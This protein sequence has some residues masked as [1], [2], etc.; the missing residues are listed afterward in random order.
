MLLNIDFFTQFLSSDPTLL[1]VLFTV[2]PMRHSPGWKFAEEIQEHRGR[3]SDHTKHLYCGSYGTVRLP[4]YNL[5]D[6][7]CSVSSH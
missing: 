4:R 3:Q 7:L 1:K 2:Q 5:G 6:L